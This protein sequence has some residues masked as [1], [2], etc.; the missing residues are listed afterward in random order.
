MSV[1]RTKSSSVSPVTRPQLI[2][3]TCFL[4]GTPASISAMQDAQVEA[5][6]VEPLDSSVSET[7]RMAY[8]NSS[9]D[10]STGSRARSASAP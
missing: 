5:M 1:S 2:P 7:A 4:I 8:G 3:A 10:G 6:E 9:T